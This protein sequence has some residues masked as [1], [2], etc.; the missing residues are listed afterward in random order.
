MRLTKREI[1]QKNDN[2]NYKKA[3]ED[4]SQGLLV[5]IIEEVCKEITFKFSLVFIYILVIYW[6]GRKVVVVC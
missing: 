3:P 2:K 4:K 6:R 1:Q 5:V